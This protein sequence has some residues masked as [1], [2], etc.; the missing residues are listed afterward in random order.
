L[1][2][3]ARLVRKIRGVS[4]WKLLYLCQ[5]MSYPET[6]QARYVPPRKRD[7]SSTD[8]PWWEQ[9]LERSGNFGSMSS[10]NSGEN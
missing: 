8:K 7:L 1:R 6:Y 5:G 2:H 9:Y 4:L 3:P 10:A